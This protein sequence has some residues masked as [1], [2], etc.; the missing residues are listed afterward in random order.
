MFLKNENL[1]YFKPFFKYDVSFFER[2]LPAVHRALAS[3]YTTILN[4]ST[5]RDGVLLIN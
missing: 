1:K 5:K 2:D 3:I 4:Y